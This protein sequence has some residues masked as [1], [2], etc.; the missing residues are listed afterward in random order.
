MVMIS[1]EQA[2]PQTGS[3][4]QLQANSGAALH[5]RVKHG[6][7]QHHPKEENDT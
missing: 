4:D 5:G 1:A 7:N 3:D 6:G 2:P